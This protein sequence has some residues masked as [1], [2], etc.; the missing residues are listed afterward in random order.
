MM[1]A[2]K[3]I[4]QSPIRILHLED[5]VLDHD[6]ARRGLEQSGLHFSILRVETLPEFEKQIGT[7]QFDIVLADY[8]LSGFTAIDAWEILTKQQQRPAFV[9]LS[10]AIG[11]LVAVEAIKLGMNV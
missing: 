10:G 7:S 5:S 4:D 9:L 6:L 2:S 8:R 11:E 3:N 1:A